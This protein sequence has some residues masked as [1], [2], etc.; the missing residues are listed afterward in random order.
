VTSSTPTSRRPGQRRPFGRF[1]RPA[2]VAVIVAL[3]VSMAA[4]GERR[5]PTVGPLLTAPAASEVTTDTD[6]EYRDVDGESLALDACLPADGGAPTAAV[7]LLH[8]GGFVSGSR[9]DESISNLCLWLAEN[10]Y[11]AF[12]TSYRFAP[13]YIYPSQTEDVAAAVEWLRES[14]QTERFHIDP[15]R[16]GALGSSAGAILALEAATA[17][18]GPSDTGSR[19]KAAVSLSGVADMT[20]DA[21]MLGTPSPEA[22]TIILTYL[23][24]TT[25]TRCD[26]A[27][28]SAVNHIDATDAPVLFVG[29]EQ[30]LVPTEQADSMAAALQTVGVPHEMVVVPGAG[31]G[32]QLMNQDVRTRTLAF[33]ATY[34]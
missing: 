31:H 25:I 18:E 15:A 2:A 5:D 23:G 21:A 29:A 26:G 7:I 11:A 34:L 28:A 14:A 8:G 16:I 32:A 30:D 1:A 6:I 17:G 20:S 4:C 10:G 22:L 27:N 9:A 12:P 24:C 3:T 33:F 19:L 13:T